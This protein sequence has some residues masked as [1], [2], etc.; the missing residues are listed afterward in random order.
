[1]DHYAEKECTQCHLLQS[2]EE[3]RPRLMSTK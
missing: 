2:P 3:F 1:V